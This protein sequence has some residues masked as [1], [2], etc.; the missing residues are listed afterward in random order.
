MDRANTNQHR[1][2]FRAGSIRLLALLCVLMLL[3][4]CVRTGQTP[5]AAAP[6]PQRMAEALTARDG[7]HI[8]AAVLYD[9]TGAGHWETTLGYLRQPLLVGL[10]VTLEDAY[11]DWETRGYD[12]IYADASVANGRAD[13][14]LAKRLTA[15]AENGGALFCDN[16]LCTFLPA[17][18]FG[19]AKFEKLDAFPETLTLPETDADKKPLQE[20]VQDFHALYTRFGDFDVMRGLDYGCG[21]RGAKDAALVRCGELALYTL[22]DVGTGCVFLTSPLLPNFFAQ[23]AFSMKPED[24]AQTSFAPTAASCNQLLLSDFASYAAKR[25]YGCAIE[26]VFGCNGSPSMAWELHYEEIDAIGNGSLYAFSDLCEDQR[27]IPSFT[28]VR[29][30]Y[31][32]FTQS[33]TMSYLLN[34]SGKAGALSFRMDLN[35]NAYSS[36]THIDSSGS[37]LKLCD[38][39]G[40]GSYFETLPDENLRLTPCALDYDGDG[41]ADFFCGSSDGNVYY[42]ENLG[43]TG[44]DGRLRCGEKKSVIPA[45]ENA[46]SAPAAADLDGDGITDLIVGTDD[47]V[48][49]WYRGGGALSFTPM[50]KLLDTGYKAQALPAAADCDGDGVTDLIVGSSCGRLT[51]YHGA[52]ADGQ[53]TAGKAVKL[54]SEKPFRELIDDFGWVS[55]SWTD[56]DADGRPDLVLGSFEGYAAVL[57]N[58]GKGGFRFKQTITM[59]ERN[60][61]GN[62]SVKLGTYLTP[63]LLDLDGDGDLDLMG[64]YEEYGLACPIDSPYFPY[65][66]QLQEQIDYCRERG[67]YVSAHSL[68][69]AYSSEARERWELEAHKKALKS[70]GLDVT[71]LGTNQHT[72]FVSALDGTQ[73]L[74]MQREAGYLWNSG[75]SPAGS[76]LRYPQSQAEN[77]IALPYYLDDGGAPFLVQNVSILPYLGAEDQALSAKYG[78]PMCAYYHCDLIFRDGPDMYRTAVQTVEDFRRENGYNFVREDQL[79]R[80]SAAACSLTLDVR[81]EDGRILLTPG[82][83]D[84]TKPLYDARYQSACGVRIA[85]ASDVDAASVTTDARVL[86]RGENTLTA[87]LDGTVA[88]CVG[89]RADSRIA[90]VNLPAEIDPAA[91]GAEIAFL[92]GGLMEVC[93]RGD[94]DTDAAGWEKQTRGTE[95]IFTKFGDAETVRIS[96]P[97]A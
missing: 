59:D 78:M 39:T 33:E 29:N 81:A 67:W 96:Y 43:F 19:G 62:D 20:L 41:D 42:F 18:C 15:F 50:G 30:P 4:G 46:F 44:L 86:W 76:T 5:L 38:Y 88:L 34:D 95:T 22:C 32:W 17:R 84:D 73:T 2:L 28:I 69:T 40:A 91:D 93:V 60:Y 89:E 82:A 45:G 21:A 71:G 51:L 63:M 10:E 23:S 66:V 92:D 1:C 77:V 48:L 79:M 80:A 90:R 49:R 24:D 6:F 65:R 75:L 58:D 3:T 94:A 14:D 12:L 25:I 72:W 55:P 85:F 61:K 54:E 27:Q 52:S 31:H 74:R 16:A 36:G 47:G 97:E 8:K 70:Y 87:A 26:R 13:K 56:L 11:G 7:Y 37:W 68:T 9:K 35:E 57:T 64:G 83:A 53:W